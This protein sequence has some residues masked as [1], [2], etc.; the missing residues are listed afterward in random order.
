MPLFF[1]IVSEEM[2][3]HIV[4]IYD[5][6]GDLRKLKDLYDS[7]SKSKLVQLLVNLFMLEL[8][9][10]NPMGLAF[11]L[12]TILHDIVSTRVKIYVFLIIFIKVIYPTYS[13]YLQSL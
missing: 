4:H 8:K 12:K 1:A 6:Y 3:H 2:S 13:H 7:N 11:E 10:D 5:F 9:D